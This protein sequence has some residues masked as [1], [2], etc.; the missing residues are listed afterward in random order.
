MSEKIKYQYIHPVSCSCGITEL[1]AGVQDSEIDDKPLLT[2][3]MNCDEKYKKENY[4]RKIK[5]DSKGKKI[6]D[7]VIQ[8]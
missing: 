3:C 5:L 6:S 7:K 1:T 2:H 4:K 8:I